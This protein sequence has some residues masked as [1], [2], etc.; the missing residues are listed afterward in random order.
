MSERY[1]KR[2]ALTGSLYGEGAPVLIAAGVLLWDN[3]AGQALV[4]LKLRNIG[5]K[6]IR[7]ANVT[8]FPLDDAG[9]P[10]G[11]SVFHSYTEQNAAGTGDF[12]Q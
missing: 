8:V 12:G 2:F 6:V 5:R 10:I 7:G 3:K 9:N 1:E 4:Q 11:A